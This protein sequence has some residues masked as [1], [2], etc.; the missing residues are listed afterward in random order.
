MHNEKVV[1]L[2][3]GNWISDK[4]PD[5]DE[6]KKLAENGIKLC[7]LHPNC[8]EILASFMDARANLNML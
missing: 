7:D 4:S 3:K 8:L 5:Q 2:A 6:T 1:L